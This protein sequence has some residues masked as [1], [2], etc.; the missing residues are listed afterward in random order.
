MLKEASASLLEARCNSYRYKQTGH[1]DS[2]AHQ[3]AAAP[4]GPVGCSSKMRQH[5]VYGVH[6]T[7]YCKHPRP[8]YIRRTLKRSS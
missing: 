5:A 4:Q 2:E 1:P 3:E 6:Y 8:Y 7:E